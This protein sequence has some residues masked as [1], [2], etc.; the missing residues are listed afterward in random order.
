[1]QNVFFTVERLSKLKEEKVKADWKGLFLFLIIFGTGIELKALHLL[2][3][4]C[5]AELHPRA[6]DCC[7]NSS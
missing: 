5:A 1:M 6:K 7:L 2:D 4:Y 3:R